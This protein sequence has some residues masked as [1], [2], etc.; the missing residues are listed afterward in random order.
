[1]TALPS[2]IAADS[3]CRAAVVRRRAVLAARRPLA[4]HVAAALEAQNSVFA[5]SSA[6]DS[7]LAA[8]RSGAAAV[9]TGQQVGLFL[10]PVFNLYKAAS[11]ICTARTLSAETGVPVVPVFW[12]QT[13]DHDLA[14]I[15]VH[16]TL[17]AGGI[18][19]SLH[20]PVDL[21]DRRSLAYR[22]LPAEVE[23]RLAD[24]QAAL[25]P[26]PHAATHIERLRRHYIPGRGW[27]AAF[28][29]VLAE[30]FADD[31]LVLLDPRDP[32]FAAEHAFV[33][34]EALRNAADIAELLGQTAHD[35]QAA[36]RSVPVH[37]RPGAPLS[38]FHPEGPD[39][40][41]FRLEPDGDGWREIGGTRR[42]TSED[43]AAQLR[44]DPLRFSTSALLRPILQ[45]RLLPT[46]AY[47]GGATEVAYFAQI[48]RLF[49]HFGMQVPLVFE[50]ASFRVIDSR[51]ARLLT[52][53]RLEAQQCEAAMDDV[54][55]CAATE[56]HLSAERLRDELLDPFLRHLDA[57][58]PRVVALDADLHVAI[59][60]TRVA[61]AAAIARLEH[62]YERALY[63]H[64]QRVTDD[65]AILRAALFPDGQPQERYFGF[66]GFA[67]RYGERAFIDRL[68]AATEPFTPQRRDL[69]CPTDDGA[70]AAGSE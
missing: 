7:N 32:A 18:P 4:P 2:S 36:G 1:V 68:L 45:D 17:A 3:S 20:L 58:T 64:N 13:E 67:A 31:G 9:V 47:V 37:I 10:G 11:A 61:I 54:L 48:E 19:L 46:A 34:G 6:R 56:E 60:K 27:S 16:H 22:P 44:D 35:L 63:R 42:F 57:A 52:R 8:L 33:H 53:W 62:R 40:P 15:A 38:F 49:G 28:A 24:L 14:E 43:L 66:S 25:E 59:D 69:L 55:R 30:L 70:N 26:F 5:S 65:V 12:L 39:G 51:C 29:G 41:R 23:P 50:R 21:A